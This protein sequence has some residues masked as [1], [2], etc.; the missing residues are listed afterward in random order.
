L[1][2]ISALVAVMRREGAADPAIH[3]VLAAAL[4]VDE[5]TARAHA[6][7]RPPAPVR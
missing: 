3:R 5:V 7:G 4:D 2:S 1:V 6:E